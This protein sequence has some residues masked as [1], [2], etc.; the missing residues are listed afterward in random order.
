MSYSDLVFIHWECDENIELILNQI[1]QAGKKAGI[2]L[3]MSTV[4]ETVK[5]QLMYVDAVLLLTIPE[6]GSSGQK[7]DMDGLLTLIN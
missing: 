5:Q 4:P 3:C 2:A 1:K 6:P 7:F